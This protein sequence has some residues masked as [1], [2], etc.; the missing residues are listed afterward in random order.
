MGTPLGS[1]QYRKTEELVN[2]CCYK[3]ER[4]YESKSVQA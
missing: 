3:E 1:I 2:K 4:V